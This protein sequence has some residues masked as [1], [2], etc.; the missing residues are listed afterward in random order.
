MADLEGPSLL[1]V[2][3]KLNKTGGPMSIP[4]AVSVQVSS[5]R[6]RSGRI[7]HDPRTGKRHAADVRLL[8]ERRREDSRCRTPRRRRSRSRRQHHSP[9]SRTPRKCRRDSRSPYLFLFGN[10]F[11][12]GFMDVGLIWKLG[13]AMHIGSEVLD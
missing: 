12:N 7:S 4:Q 13:R 11:G 10:C 6:R 3:A 5:H 1:Q 9:R 2:Q 8:R